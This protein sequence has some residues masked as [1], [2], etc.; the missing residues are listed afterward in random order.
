MQL[1]KRI[2]ASYLPLSGLGYQL[3]MYLRRL[4]DLVI[5]KAA[6]ISRDSFLELRL[7]PHLHSHL[8]CPCISEIQNTRTPDAVSWNTWLLIEK[9]ATEVTDYVSFLY[10][11]FSHILSSYFLCLISFLGTIISLQILCQQDTSTIHSYA[12]IFYIH[13]YR[14][15]QNFLPRV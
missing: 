11:L 15:P 3:V 4:Y 8:P 13:I 12:L 5:T 9:S 6:E 1:N 10:N 7:S 14:S 2:G